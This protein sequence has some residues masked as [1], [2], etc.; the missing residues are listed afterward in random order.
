MSRPKNETY[1][2]SKQ[3][4]CYD[5]HVACPFGDKL[6]HRLKDYV[7]ETSLICRSEFVESKYAYEVYFSVSDNQVSTHGLG[8]LLPLFVM[9]MNNLSTV[10]CQGEKCRRNPANS[11]GMRA[12]SLVCAQATPGC[13]LW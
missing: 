9:R 6:L 7:Y 2:R 12:F 13:M 11:G 5:I 1:L 3:Q 4:W 10:D 8:E